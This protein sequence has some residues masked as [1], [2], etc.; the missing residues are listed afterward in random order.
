MSYYYYPIPDIYLRLF[1]AFAIAFDITSLFLFVPSVLCNCRSYLFITLSIRS[2][3]GRTDLYSLRTNFCISLILLIFTMALR[4]L[5]VCAFHH[6][7]VVSESRELRVSHR[8][9]W[10]PAMSCSFEYFTY[11]SVRV[12]SKL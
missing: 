5:V 11:I 9:G 8:T 10:K 4:Y 1:K 2:A 7:L 3:V 6:T 12:I